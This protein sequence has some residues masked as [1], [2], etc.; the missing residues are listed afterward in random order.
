GRPG[1]MRGGQMRG[2]QGAPMPQAQPQRPP[3]GLN[4]NYGRELL[5]LHTLGVDGGYTQQD[6]IAV[7]RAFTGWT[8]E[9]PR[10]GGGDFEFNERIHD[11][12]DKVV[13][14]QKLPS[15]GGQRDGERVLDLL[16]K[17]P[18]TAR[19]IA[20]KLATRFVSDTPPPALVDR[21]AK[22]FLETGGD[23]RKVT[24]TILLSP[25]FMADAARG[26][27]VKTPFEFVAS[28]LRVT[29]ADVRNAAPVVLQLRTLGM[30]LYGAQPP[31]GYDDT[32]ASWVNTGA[33]LNRMN[34]AVSLVSNKLQG[35]RVAAEIDPDAIVPADRMSPNTRATVAQAADRQKRLALVLGSP[36]FQKR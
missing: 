20:T 5:E 6:V 23:L 22:V 25:E 19:H 10:G 26:A 1:Q 31:T 11:A 27:K 29:S 14:G 32:A 13:L 12:G 34:F 9:R 33:L 17:H 35:A 8:I 24:R 15:G 3:R 18:A 36:E 2:G 4:E 30:P 7:A 16:A 28:A 21:A